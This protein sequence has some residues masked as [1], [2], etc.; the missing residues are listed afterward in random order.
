MGNAGGK[1]LPKSTKGRVDVLHAPVSPQNVAVV[2]Q[3]HRSE[4]QA[5]VMVEAP[6]DG[7]LM[8]PA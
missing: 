4:Q 2:E 6:L 7:R 1:K 3:V 8:G 5:L